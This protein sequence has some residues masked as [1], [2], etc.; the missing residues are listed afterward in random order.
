[1]KH[2]LIKNI[3]PKFFYPFSIKPRPHFILDIGIANNSY[4]EFKKIYPSSVYHG[5]DYIKGDIKFNKDDRFIL[6]NL[7]SP[8]ALR[9]LS[10]IYDMIIINHV[11]EH[12][13][14][15]KEVFIRL[16]NLLAPGG[17]LYAEFPSIRTAQERKTKSSYHFHDDA[18]HKQFYIVEELANLAILSGCKVI[19]C[20]PISTTLKNVLSPFRALFAYFMGRPYGPFMLHTQNKIDHIFLERPILAGNS[21]DSTLG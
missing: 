7:E 14:S 2:I 8:D 13:T 16:L 6:A 5:V 11:L 18:T 3:K 21:D 4:Y 19:S 15:G 12:L 9:D 1:M 17:V 10:P 20:G